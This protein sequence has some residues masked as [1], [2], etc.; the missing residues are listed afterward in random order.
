[1]NRSFCLLIAVV[2]IMASLPEA[3]RAQDSPLPSAQQVASQALHRRAVEAVI[4]GMPI[5]SV[6]AMREAFFRDAG[7]KY[8][9]IVY[10]SKGSDWKNQTTTPNSTSLYIY[11]NFNTKDGPVVL[12]FPAAAGAGL[13]GTMLDA[14]ETPLTDV[15]PKGADKGK[16]G[17]YII[18]PPDY[19][20]AIPAGH[21][22]V[23]SSTFNGYALF[24][25]IPASSADSDIAAAIA[26]VKK[27]RLYPHAA[28]S[29]PPE[30]HFIDMAGKLFD[31]IVPFDETF[32]VRL[33]RMINEEPVQ[34]RDLVAM[35]QLLTLGIEKGKAYK[36]D[37]ASAPALKLAAKDAHAGFIAALNKG[38]PWWAGSMW[39]LPENL[40]PKTAFSFQT[41]D[42]LGVDGRGMIFF[43]AYAPPAELGSA[44]FYLTGVHDA[45]GHSLE[46]SKTYRLRIAPD[47]PASQFWA[48]TVYDLDSAGFI[49]ESPRVGLDAYQNLRKNQ[50]GSIDVYFGPTP[51]AGEESNWIYT[52]PHQRWFSMFRFYGPMKPIFDKTWRL[53]DIEPVN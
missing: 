48:V 27:L 5:V 31:A 38:E 43:L 13:F 21:I 42:Y 30:Q 53:G 37:P 25:A 49:R 16:G 20:G 18:L 6:D 44:T 12:D 32:Y 7:A 51:P 15:G 36:P 39:V 35:G 40:G 23:R 11:F 45:Q 29:H 4:W 19:K 47:V 34:T 33:A 2:C 46:G 14:W 50:D 10:W 22:A 3:A 24:R 1:M 28:Q 41:P 26:L 9:D 52:A 17:K 8:G